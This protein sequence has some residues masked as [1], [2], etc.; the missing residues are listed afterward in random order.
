[1]AMTHFAAECPRC[2]TRLRVRWRYTGQNVCCRY[3]GQV[4]LAVAPS[5][6]AGAPADDAP[7]AVLE[8]PPG[9]REDGRVLAESE[10]AGRPGPV[11]NGEPDPGGKDTAP[12]LMATLL[13]ERAEALARETAEAVDAE[14]LRRDEAER[15]RAEAAAAR[16]EAELAGLRKDMSE[17]LA[18]GADRHRAECDRW[19]QDRRD[20]AG[21]VDRLRGDLGAGRERLAALEQTLEA[22]R[23]SWRDE[24]E[25]ARLQAE[26]ER[27]AFQTLVDRLSAGAETA[28]LRLAQRDEQ[29]RA[30]TDELESLRRT[31]GEQLGQSDALRRERDALR[32]ERDALRTARQTADFERDTLR[33]ARQT[34]DFERDTLRAEAE[35]LH[36]EAETVR[37]EL[38]RSRAEA[39]SARSERDEARSLAEAL[40]A[41]RDQAQAHRDRASG[42]AEALRDR[43]LGE[44]Q[45]LRDE[46]DRALARADAFERDL[47]ALRRALDEARAAAAEADTRHREEA[48]A[49]AA[50][51]DDAGR[52][53]DELARE[54]DALAAQLE[55]LRAEVDRLRDALADAIQ[56]PSAQPP[57]A[58]DL[59]VL[60][61]DLA[62][63]SAWEPQPQPRPADAP[64]EPTAVVAVPVGPPALP[65]TLDDLTA[66]E[67]HVDLLRRLLHTP[68]EPGKPFHAVFDTPRFQAVRA[69]LREASLL[70]ERLVSQVE[71][72]R[73]QKDLLWH[74]MVAQRTD[75]IHR[76]RRR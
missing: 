32:D 65:P 1:M 50:T 51:A 47:D 48:D 69:K 25:A 34:A 40:R 46:R 9:P 19:E 74:L 20:L 56:R 53:R 58:A 52:G 71:R 18:A 43:A 36:A 70:A 3:C 7:S 22:E 10:A 31:S 14:R 62:R 37:A 29:L 44:A 33:T 6:G 64:P 57:T 68:V 42:E 15:L 30:L 12:D 76:H 8:P 38:D 61:R 26:S 16:H 54:R 28:A 49:L 73:T 39:T 75:E 60:S 5:N 72:S 2:Q 66:V 23:R 45:A 13:A 41:A 24:A 55:A 4:F 59:P 21:E 27:A 63:W 11:E 35:S 67:G 17:A